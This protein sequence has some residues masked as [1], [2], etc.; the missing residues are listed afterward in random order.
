MYRYN[1]WEGKHRLSCSELS[2]VGYLIVFVMHTKYSIY[3]KVNI[4]NY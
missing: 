4:L 1:L 2:H 3:A